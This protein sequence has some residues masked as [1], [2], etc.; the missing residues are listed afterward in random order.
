MSRKLKFFSLR[1]K[2]IFFFL[3]IIS[4]LIWGFSI[5][6]A[7]TR[8]VKT[9]LA[10]FSMEE[11]FENKL[12]IVQ[13]NSLLPTSNHSNP[14][15]IIKKVNVIVTGYSSS[16]FET[17]DDPYTTAAGT[18]V[19]EGIVANNLLPIGTKIK[20]PELYGE[21]IF[22]VE[23]RMHWKK[24]YYHVDIWF[25]SYWQAKN[26]GAKKTRIEILEG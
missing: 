10:D 9:S 23:D 12:A 2:K 8:E 18:Q 7:K 1:R 19:R 4:V 14:A 21:K 16:I 13:G 20:I 6:E 24:G 11:V 25:P 22:V 5:F 17:D 15:R 26:F 3:L